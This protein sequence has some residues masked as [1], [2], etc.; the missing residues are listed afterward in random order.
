V[1]AL[2]VE[3][4]DGVGEVLEH[5]L[6][7]ALAL[8]DLGRPAPFAETALGLRWAPGFFGRRGRG[9]LVAGA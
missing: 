6:E 9:R 2:F 3:S 5:R 4:R 8:A 1:A 7:R